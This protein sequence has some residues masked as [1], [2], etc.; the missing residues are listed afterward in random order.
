MADD[1]IRNGAKLLLRSGKIA[2]FDCDVLLPSGGT[3]ACTL[4]WDWKLPGLKVRRNCDNQE[5]P[6][7]C[8][9][10]FFVCAE[11]AALCIKADAEEVYR[12]AAETETKRQNR[13]VAMFAQHQA[14]RARH[15]NRNLWQ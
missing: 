5:A 1:Q 9:T 15:W 6:V 12:V 8:R 13:E 11:D 3:C 7:T 4:V 2:A 10:A 14:N